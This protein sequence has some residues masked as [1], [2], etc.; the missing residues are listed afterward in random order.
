MS[1]RWVRLL[2]GREFHIE[3]TMRMWDALFAQYNPE[4]GFVLADYVCVAMCHYVRKQRTHCKI[5]RLV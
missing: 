1:R 4:K 5:V 2:F 3:D